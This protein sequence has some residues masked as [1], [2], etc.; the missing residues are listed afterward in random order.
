[1]NQMTIF[2]FVEGENEISNKKAKI[3]KKNPKN[4]KKKRVINNEKKLVQT[5]IDLGQNIA[6]ITCPTCGMIYSQGVED[7]KLH[8]VYH[9]KFLTPKPLSFSLPLV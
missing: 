9:N 5:I 4:N 8:K 3:E 7:E 6:P 1:M 2:S